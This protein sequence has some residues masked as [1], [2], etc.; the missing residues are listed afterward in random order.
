MLTDALLIALLAGLAGVDLFDGLTHFHRPVVMGPLVGL[1]LGD[2]Y[3][4]LL[5]GGT[6]E[7]VWMG[8]VPLAGAQPPNVVI[9]GVIGTAF[10]IL[11][12]AD[13]KVAIG[14]AVPFSIAVQGCITLLFTLFSPM[15]HRCDRMVKALN[16]RGIERVNYLGIGILFIFYFVVAFLPIYF[17]ADAASAMVQK[18]PGWLLDGLAVAGGMMPAIG[19]SL[20]MK[21]MMKKTYVAYFILGFISV[22]FLKLPILAVALGALAIALIDF[23]NTQ[24]GAAEATARPAPQEDAEDGI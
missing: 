22:T 23:F 20:L 13:P 4:G 24:R 16:W 17:G 8:M 9:G 3:T 2:V 7:L 11:T 18:A 12:K 10:A 15:M 1:I 6:L 5:V 14:V 21:V 19:F